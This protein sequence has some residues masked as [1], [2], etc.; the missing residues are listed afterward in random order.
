MVIVTSN[1]AKRLLFMSFI[2]HVH[3]AELKRSQEDVKSLLADLPPGFRLLV[4]YGPM[5]S[6]DLACAPEIG[7]SME[8]IDQSGV[9][10]VVRVM[11]DPSKD[12]GMNIL[13]LFHYRSNPQVVTCDHMA[14]AAK[15]LSL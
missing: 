9:S 7:R 14:D 12:I 10:M 8:L 5:E 15:K 6:M 11:P 4:D 2:Q 3:P 13:T 1:K